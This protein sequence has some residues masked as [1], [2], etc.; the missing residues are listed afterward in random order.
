[1]STQD[2]ITLNPGSGGR[3]STDYISGTGH[4]RHVKLDIGGNNATSPITSTNALPVQLYGL[5]S[6]WTTVPV[7]GGTNGQAIPISGTI[8]VGAVSITGGTLKNS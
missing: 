7:G 5:K 6:N 8:S 4:V 2:N 3:A 1:M